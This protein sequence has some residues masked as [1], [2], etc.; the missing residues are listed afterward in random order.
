MVK[1]YDE[2]DDE[3]REKADIDLHKV[4]VE[5]SVGKKIDRGVEKGIITKEDA[6]SLEKAITKA[7]RKKMYDW[8]SDKK[9]EKSFDIMKELLLELGFKEVEILMKIEKA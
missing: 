2:L 4:T 3:E 6:E 7:I 9:G 8:W 1:S 5:R